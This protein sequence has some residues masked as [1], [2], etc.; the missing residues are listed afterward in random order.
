MNEHFLTESGI[1]AI[2]QI[3]SRIMTGSETIQT[4]HIYPVGG[5]KGGIGKS[6]ITANLGYLL[7]RK[8]KK[9][10][11]VDLDLGAPNLHTFLGVDHLEQGLDS[12]LSKRII[13]LE[14]VVT[15]TKT[16][17]LFFVSSANCR[18]EAPNLYAAQKE[19]II[20]SIRGLDFDYVFLDLGA[21]TGFNMLDFFLTSHQGLCVLTSEPTAIENVFAFIKAAYFRMI[22]RTLTLK[23]FNRFTNHLD[24]SGNPVDQTF[25]IL[26]EIQKQA[27][28]M[29]EWLQN[30]LSAFQFFFIVNQLHKRDDPELGTKIEKVCNHHFYS[31]F[32]FLGNIRYDE[33]VHN[34]VLLRCLF[35]T[36]YSHTPTSDEFRKI[37]CSFEAARLPSDQE[38]LRL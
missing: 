26:K 37:A 23:T 27:P 6:L 21:G 31:R 4:T 16:P 14:E 5:G 33:N 12:F 18:V 20:R 35:V 15:P 22:K 19:K 25:R 36:H 29:A 9:V 1:F 30:K 38:K 17:G 10:L 8:G 7:A 13:C 2:F 11:L 28:D 34:S 32:R 3:Q 24:L